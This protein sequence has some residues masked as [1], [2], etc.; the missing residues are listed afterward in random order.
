MSGEPYGWWLLEC[1]HYG[2]D[3][4]AEPHSPTIR[5]C[6]CPQVEKFSGHMY[7]DH[8]DRRRVLAVKP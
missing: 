8:P 3:S 5:C 6:I 1:G 4:D 7:R 2:H